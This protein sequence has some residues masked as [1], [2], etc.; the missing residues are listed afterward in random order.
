MTG[1]PKDA[2]GTAL[3]RGKSA[4]Q[5]IATATKSAGRKLG[6]A[7]VLTGDLNKDGKV[8]QEDAKIAG[9]KARRITSKAAETAGALARKA[10]KH[11]MVKDAAAGAAI[12]AAVGIP[13]P[14]I[15]P[16]AGATVGAIAGVAKNLRS[17]GKRGPAAKKSKS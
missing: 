9:A 2:R 17:A 11:D 5:R 15:G 4:A 3:A 10:S 8:D 6:K 12:G 1:K 14:V 16:V 7:A 13:V